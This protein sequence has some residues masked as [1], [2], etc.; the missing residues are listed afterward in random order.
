VGYGG[1]VADAGRALGRSGDDGVDGVMD[2]DALDLDRVYV[3]A[4]RYTSGNNIGP[5]E[6][7]KIDL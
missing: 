4:K 1:S 2:Q 3:Q 5:A 7:D 6:L